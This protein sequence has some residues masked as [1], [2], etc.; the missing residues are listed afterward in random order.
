MPQPHLNPQQM[1]RYRND[2][3]YWKWVAG[4]Q[5]AKLWTCSWKDRSHCLLKII[6]SSFCIESDKQTWICVFVFNIN[7]C[8]EIYYRYC[9]HAP[10]R[11]HIFVSLS[12][13]CSLICSHSFAISPC[14]NINCCLSLANLWQV[15]FCVF[16]YTAF[17]LAKFSST[18]FCLNSFEL[19]SMCIQKDF[20]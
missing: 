1:S 16:C 10:V 5:R 15:H 20:L 9:T 17:R 2:R 14:I 11:I 19:C 7:K 8:A 18:K 12:L 13:S 6:P 3:I 4:N